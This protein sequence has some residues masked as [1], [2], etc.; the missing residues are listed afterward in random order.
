VSDH[1]PFS[2]TTENLFSMQLFLI[3]ASIPLMFLGAVIDERGK[4][5]ERFM[6]AFRSSPDAVVICRWKDC[7]ILEVNKRWEQVFGHR[8]EE[9][10]GKTAVELKI[11]AS[12]ADRE[13]LLAATA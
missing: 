2:A 13:R 5:E 10:I 1:G 11:Y 6:K 7:Q 4:A 9:A 12:N 3:V 8:R